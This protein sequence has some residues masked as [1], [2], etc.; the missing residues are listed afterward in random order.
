LLSKAEQLIH[1][2]TNKETDNDEN[3]VQI[4]LIGHSTAKRQKQLIFLTSHVTQDLLTLVFAL[5]NR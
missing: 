1:N 5:L 4:N 3:Q 2:V